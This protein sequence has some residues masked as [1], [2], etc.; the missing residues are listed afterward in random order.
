MTAIYV[1]AANANGV[2]HGFVSGGGDHG[3]QLDVPED[4]GQ[5]PGRSATRTV[6]GIHASGSGC[7]E[8]VR[9]R[10]NRLNMSSENPLEKRKSLLF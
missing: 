1:G 2:P 6:R 9:I 7:C 4:G 10:M 8:Q 3:R 5:V